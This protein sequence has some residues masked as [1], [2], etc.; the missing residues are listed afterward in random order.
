MD[1]PQPII[2]SVYEKAVMETVGHMESLQRTGDGGS[3]G[4]V[5]M[6]EYHS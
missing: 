4:R 3:P 5:N 1:F 6:A 2:Y